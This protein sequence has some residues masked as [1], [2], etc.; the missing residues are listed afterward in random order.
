MTIKSV[1]KELKE[2]GYNVSFYKRKDGGIRITRINGETFTGSSGNK[3]ARYI[4]GVSLTE[5]QVRALG[6]LKTPTGKGSYNKRRK[7]PID[8]ETKKQIQ[9]LQ[10]QYRKAGKT[11]GKPTIRNYRY[12]LKTKG[13]KEADRLLKQ[14]ERRILGYAYEENVDALLLR[15]KRI[16][17]YYETKNESFI[18]FNKAIEK[19]ENAS[20]WFRDKWIYPIYEILYEIEKGTKDPN[21]GGIEIIDVMR[22]M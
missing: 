9:K 12:I 3:K 8:E 1:I 22:T 11:E 17:A 6:R 14:A 7:I 15:M 16:K 18:F 10:R 5:A 19:V 4:I 13:K 20:Q 2:I 21:D